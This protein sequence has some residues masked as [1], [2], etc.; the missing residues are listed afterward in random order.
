VLNAGLVP[1]KFRQGI[2]PISTR[3]QSNM[4]V[5]ECGEFSD[6][7]QDLDRAKGSRM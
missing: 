7:S 3:E 5:P 6:I 4:L 2:A 1:Y